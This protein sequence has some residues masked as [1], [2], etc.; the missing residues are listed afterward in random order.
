MRAPVAIAALEHGVG[1]VEIGAIE[2][3]SLGDMRF[4]GP[5]RHRYMLDGQRHLRAGDVA[6]AREGRDEGGIAGDEP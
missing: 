6:E 3:A 2:R 1:D 5:G 4:V